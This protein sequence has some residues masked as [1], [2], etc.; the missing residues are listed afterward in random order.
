[1]DSAGTGEVSQGEGAFRILTVTGTS[2]D[3]SG[4]RKK[5]RPTTK[6][7]LEPRLRSGW[8]QQMEIQRT[9]R[10]FRTLRRRD[11][12][13]ALSSQR[14]RWLFVRTPGTRA[15]QGHLQRESLTPCSA[16]DYYMINY[17]S[18]SS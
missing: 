8:S 2:W 14:Q 6:R 3:T 15:L 13:N 9:G 18:D 7:S 4:P 17:I 11:A 16:Y 1:M 10:S 12:P 5:S